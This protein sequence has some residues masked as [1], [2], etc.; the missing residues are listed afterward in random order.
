M[1]ERI[2]WEEFKKDLEV[3]IANE[4]IWAMGS[5]GEECEMH[6]DNIERMKEQIEDIENGDYDSILHYYDEAVLEEYMM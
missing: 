4:K 3:S 2:D 6:L 5:T 1:K